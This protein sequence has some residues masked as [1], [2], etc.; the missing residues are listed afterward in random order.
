M[1]FGDF[2][3]DFFDAEPKKNEND[4]IDAIKAYQPKIVFS[5]VKQNV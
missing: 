2:D 3:D 4:F 1:E 5:K